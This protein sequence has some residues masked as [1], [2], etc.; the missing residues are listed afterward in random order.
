MPH[1][2]TDAGN[3]AAG[4][5][6]AV[7]VQRDVGRT[8]HGWREGTLSM[9]LR[10]L[11]R[12]AQTGHRRFLERASERPA[13]RFSSSSS[14]EVP[15]ANA[16]GIVRLRINDQPAARRK[17][18][19]RCLPPYGAPR[20]SHCVPAD[21]WPLPCARRSV[22]RRVRRRHTMHPVH[23]RNATAKTQGRASRKPVGHPEHGR[24]L[25]RQRD[26]CPTVG[27]HYRAN[28]SSFSDS[29]N[30][31]TQVLQRSLGWCPVDCGDERPAHS[32]ARRVERLIANIV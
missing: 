32:L 21:T 9:R 23:R 31:R 24:A 7:A 13:L 19:V 2:G 28:D 30:S 18:T 12:S 8:N 20:R 26:G 17:N 29:A 10:V 16:R 4:P 15:S 6:P 1:A 14:A 22:G 3:P 11:A 25:T 5:K 27:L